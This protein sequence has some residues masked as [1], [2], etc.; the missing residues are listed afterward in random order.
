LRIDPDTAEAVLAH[1]R[2]GVKG[3]YDQWERLP[4]KREALERWSAFLADL[5]RPQPI[6]TARRKRASMV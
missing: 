4:E 1:R 3:I 5:I 2:S 6:E